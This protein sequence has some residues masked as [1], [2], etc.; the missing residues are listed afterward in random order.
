MVASKPILYDFIAVKNP[1]SVTLQ[2]V[3]MSE[4]HLDEETL[5]RALKCLKE[6]EKANEG[7]FQHYG[8]L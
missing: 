2:M 3:R 7:C 4:Y 5:R 6:L 8:Y 1:T